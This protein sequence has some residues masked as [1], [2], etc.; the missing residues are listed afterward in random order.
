[1]FLEG[2]NLFLNELAARSVEP[3]PISE[4]ANLIPSLLSEPDNYQQKDEVGRNLVV[5][6]AE[7]KKKT[8]TVEFHFPWCVDKHFEEVVDVREKYNP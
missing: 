2:V 5:M 7:K 8:S 1:M 6:D 3:D 4:L